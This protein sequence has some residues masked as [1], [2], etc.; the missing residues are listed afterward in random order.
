MRTLELHSV[1]A[2]IYTPNFNLDREKIHIWATKELAQN[3]G[4]ATI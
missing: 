3:L 1:G 2:I 4:V